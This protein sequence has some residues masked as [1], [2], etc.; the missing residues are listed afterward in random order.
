MH[1]PAPESPIEESEVRKC[2]LGKRLGNPL[3]PLTGNDAKPEQHLH[4][5]HYVY[6]FVWLSFGVLA[7]TVLVSSVTAV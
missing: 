1:G 6:E 2:S 3:T 4:T 5:T 7:N